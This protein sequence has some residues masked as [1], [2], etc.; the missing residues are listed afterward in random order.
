MSVATKRHQMALTQPADFYGLSLILG[1]CEI[2]M[3]ETC[4]CLAAILARNLLGSKIE[5]K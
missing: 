2:N 5:I 3:W 1:G 4:R